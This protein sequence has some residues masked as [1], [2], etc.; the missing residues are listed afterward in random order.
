MPNR[1]MSVTPVL[2]SVLFFPWAASAEPALPPEQETSTIGQFDPRD[3]SGIWYRRA[4]TA[5]LTRRSPR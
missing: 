3:F 1:L 2:V 5:A 4:D